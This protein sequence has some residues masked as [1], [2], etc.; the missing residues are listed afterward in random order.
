VRARVYVVI[1]QQLLG[2]NLVS[3]VNI[4]VLSSE[5][6]SLSPHSTLPPPLL[7]TCSPTQCAHA[8]RSLSLRLSCTLSLSLVQRD[9]SLHLTVSPSFL[10]RFV[11]NTP[12]L[13]PELAT[14]SRLPTLCR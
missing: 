2:F 7:A 1:R 12:T 6:V 9:Y 14:I 5:F 10:P 13:L 8:S 3:F 4:L 11:E